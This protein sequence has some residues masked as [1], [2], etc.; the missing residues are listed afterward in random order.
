MMN[1][2]SKQEA[3][4]KRSR[5]EM[6]DEV[7]SMSLIQDLHGH[8]DRVWSV[9]WNPNSGLAGKPAML[10]SC[11]GDKTIRV[12]QH[13]PSTHPTSPSW[14]CVVRSTTFNSKLLLF[15]I[16]IFMLSYVLMY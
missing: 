7:H 11:G 10:A 12:W 3:K 5:K 1:A 16:I 14:S 8:T 6:E 9:A 15:A 2:T 13:G 4:R